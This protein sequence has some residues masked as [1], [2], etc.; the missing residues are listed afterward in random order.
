MRT[1]LTSVWILFVAVACISG[2]GGQLPPAADP[3]QG[4]EA[5]QSVLEAWKQGEKAPA[6]AE[7]TPPV[8]VSDE[9]WQQGYQLS[10][11]K[12]SPRDEISG[13]NLR[14]SVQLTLRDAQGYTEEKEVVYLVETGSR[15]SIIREGQ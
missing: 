9:D 1:Q 8:H 10:S 2:C 5:L 11:F 12:V 6:L 15:V 3:G 13:L 14:C 4:R 7:R